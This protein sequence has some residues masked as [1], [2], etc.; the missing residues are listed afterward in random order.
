[1]PFTFSHPALILPL[2][3]LPRRFYSFTG[4]VAGSLMPDFEYF[5]RLKLQSHFS[6]TFMG[7]FA[8][9]LPVGVLLAYIFHSLVRDAL[10][11]NLP[12]YFRKHLWQ[13]KEQD[14][15][16]YFRK[17]WIVVI[18]SVLVGAASHIFWDSFTHEDTLFVRLVP[19][20]LGEVTLAGINF[21]LYRVVQ[22]VSTII[23]GALLLYALKTQPQE[24]ELAAYTKQSVTYWLTVA[25]V[26]VFVLLLRFIGGLHYSSYSHIIASLLGG[27]L[28]GVLIAS[29]FYNRAVARSYKTQ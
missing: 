13:F 22:H 15:A 1:M 24:K 6:H 29:V 26:A 19:V 28:W 5:F 25:A 4:L 3:Y 14:W 23:G 27:G 9:N 10:I 17:N 11:D 2:T 8:F 21:P 12:D 20:L 7:L 16:A 18:V